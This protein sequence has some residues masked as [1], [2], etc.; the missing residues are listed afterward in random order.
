MEPLVEREQFINLAG[1][2][3]SNQLPEQSPLSVYPG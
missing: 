3:N 1:Q 2:S